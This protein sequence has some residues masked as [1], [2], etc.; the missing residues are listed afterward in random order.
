[1]WSLLPRCP[2]GYRGISA[3]PVT[4][5][6]SSLLSWN[7][8]EKTTQSKSLV[9]NKQRRKHRD[10]DDDDDEEDED[11]WNGV[12]S[13]SQTMTGVAVSQQHPNTRQHRRLLITAS[14]LALLTAA[15]AIA[16]GR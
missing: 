14:C 10:D 16:P 12:M 9:G 3:D 5:L 4:V 13:Q 1:M 15:A 11:E 8:E 6:N 2:R 7:A